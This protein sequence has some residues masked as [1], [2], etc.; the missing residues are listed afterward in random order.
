MEKSEEKQAIRETILLLSRAIVDGEVQVDIQQ[1]EQTTVY[2]IKVDQKD[3]GKLLGK[4]G[5]NIQSIRTIL[6]AQS[7]KHKIRAVCLVE[8]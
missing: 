8:E 4:Q 5:R 7:A 2:R 1:G 6:A 3:L